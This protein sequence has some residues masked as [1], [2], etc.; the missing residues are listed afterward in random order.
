MPRVQATAWRCAAWLG[1]TGVDG[2]QPAFDRMAD[3]WTALAD[4]ASAPPLLAEPLDANA[5][6]KNPAPGLFDDWLAEVVEKNDP[7]DM[8]ETYFYPVPSIF[9]SH[10]VAGPGL[11]QHVLAPCDGRPEKAKRHR[12]ED[13]V[14]YLLMV[15]LVLRALDGSAEAQ[16]LFADELMHNPGVVKPSTC[17]AAPWLLLGYPPR[18]GL[19]Y[20]RNNSNTSKH[21]YNSLAWP[22]S[23]HQIK[24]IF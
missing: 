20:A 18:A 16:T 17:R 1:P 4:A 14:R 23:I 5:R 15:G 3:A 10:P 7:A 11:M 12:P 6:P 21:S 2:A 22:L 13:Q 8:P 24:F 19:I 9:W